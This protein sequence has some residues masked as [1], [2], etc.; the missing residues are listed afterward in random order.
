M[1]VKTTLNLDEREYGEAQR[2]AQARGV[3]VGE[4][5]T[6]ALRDARLRAWH[7]RPDRDPGPPAPS[8]DSAEDEDREREL[9]A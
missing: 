9:A 6:R 5:V 7:R 4:Y 1:V 2:L 3:T 8:E